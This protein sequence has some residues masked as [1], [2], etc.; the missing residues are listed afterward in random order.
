MLK[1]FR[2]KGESVVIGTDVVVKIVEINTNEDGTHSVELGVEA[3]K[4]VCIDRE[5]IRA[6]RVARVNRAFTDTV[7]E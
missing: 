4:H 7:T 1:L 5:E 3:P 2:K 6:H